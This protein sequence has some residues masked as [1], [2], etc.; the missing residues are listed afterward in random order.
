MRAAPPTSEFTVY[1]KFT[2]FLDPQEEGGYTVTC[3]ELPE[4][5]TEGDSIEESLDNAIDAF[6]STCELYEHIGRALPESIVISRQQ[7]PNKI[8]RFETINPKSQGGG[9]KIPY[10]FKA[11]LDKSSI[12][13]YV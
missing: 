7:R 1:C 12:G 6:K 8:S 9:S 3:K 2:V 11:M 13:A 5:I 10:C 4:L